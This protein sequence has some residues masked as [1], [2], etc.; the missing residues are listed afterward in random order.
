MWGEVTFCRRGEGRGSRLGVAEEH[1]LVKASQGV[2]SRMSVLLDEDVTRRHDV[3][4][5]HLHRHPAGQ[6]QLT[7]QMTSSR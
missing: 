6:Q 3:H 2:V 5:N 7:R 1:L 4:D